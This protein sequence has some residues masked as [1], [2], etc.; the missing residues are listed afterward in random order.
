[1]STQI[2]PRRLWRTVHETTNPQERLDRVRQA[3]AR[4]EPALSALRAEVTG[5]EEAQSAYE[6]HPGSIAGAAREAGRLRTFAALVLCLDLPVQYLLNSAA[7]PDVASWKVA[8][9]SLGLPLGLAGAIHYLGEPLLYDADRPFRSVRIAK[10]LSAISFLATGL[11]ATVF[12]FARQASEQV[13]GYLVGLTTLA[14]WTVAEALPLTAGFTAMWARMLLRPTLHSERVQKA[15]EEIATL[16]RLLERLVGEKNRLESTGSSPR[17]PNKRSQSSLAGAATST[18]LALAAV[19]ASGIATPAGAQPGSQCGLFVDRTRSL[20]DHHRKEAVRMVMAQLSTIGGELGC[21]DLIV[22]SF[23]D[24]GPFAPRRSLQVPLPPR[25]RDCQSVTLPAAGHKGVLGDVRGFRDHFR[26]QAVE[27]CQN[28]QE[29]LTVAFQEQ[30]KQFADAAREFLSVP[31]DPGA[32][33]TDLLGLLQSLL[34]SGVRVVILVTDGLET[35]HADEDLR[36]PS[37]T[38]VVFLLV[39]PLPPYGDRESVRR[40][41]ARWK[42]IG[43][44]AIPYTVLAVPHAW[45]RMF[46]QAGQA[47]PVSSS[48]D[49]PR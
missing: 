4:V 37:G 7:L 14:V 32:S 15:R 13:A 42:G 38:R 28:E 3:L 1:M 43:V 36:T 17:E 10:T 27:A 6:G 22:G 29:S 8:L 11:A 33:R 12:L 46:S 44:V 21:T 41:V 26:H 39:P 2:D 35:V 16:E 40:A 45:T 24:E 9:G 20:N 5:L 48:S 47:L 30:N 25:T 23:A 18:L 34:V 31:Q 49:R 19:C